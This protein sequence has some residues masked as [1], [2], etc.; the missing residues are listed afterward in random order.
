[1]SGFVQALGWT[2]LHFLW[3]GLLIGCATALAWAALRNARPEARYAVG[4]GALLA[5]LA[6]PAA[7]L[8]LR[9]ADGDAT[10]ALY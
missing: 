3:Q 4:C 5:C 2:L 6:W 9:L 8:S 10:G 1:M 7:G